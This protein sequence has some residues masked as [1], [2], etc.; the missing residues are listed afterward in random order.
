MAIRPA[1]VAASGQPLGEEAAALH[2]HSI[3]VRWAGVAPCTAPAIKKAPQGSTRFQGRI[4]TDLK[5]IKTEEQYH[6]YVAEA[7][8]LT[9]NGMKPG[10]AEAD[11]LELLVKL[12][13][14]YE[15]ERFM[16]HHPDPISAIRYVMHERGLRQK[17]LAPLLGGK[18]RASEILSGKRPLT[19]G[20]VR[21]LSDSLHIPAEILIRD[22][23]QQ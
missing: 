3:A 20:M 21:A 11:R 18:N 16:N 22:P 10:S 19:L 9:D 2:S 7:K 13:E 17:D 1:I 8:Q 4:V 15:R 6:R 5:V 14:N 12:I 23:K